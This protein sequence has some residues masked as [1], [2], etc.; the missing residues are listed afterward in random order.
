ME[1]ILSKIFNNDVSNENSNELTVKE[2]QSISLQVADE[3][4][5]KKRISN[6]DEVTYTYSAK[7]A[8][9]EANRCLQCKNPACIK[10]CPVSVKIPEFLKNVAKGDFK[11]AYE[12]LKKDTLLPSICGRVCPQEKQCQQEC[13]LGKSLKDVNKAVSIG[14]IE[15]FVADYA[16][17]HNFDD[18]FEEIKSNGK[19]VAVVGS[20]PCGLA[21]SADLRR[22]GYEVTVFE[23]FHKLGGVLIYGIPEFRLPNI[24]VEKEIEK[25]KKMGVNFIT[26]FVIGRTAT[27][28]QLKE[29]YGFQAIFISTGAGL[30]LF[31]GIEGE[32]LVGV[33]SANEFLT[34]VNLMS[35]YKEEADTPLYSAKKNSRSRGRKC[36]YGRSESSKKIRLRG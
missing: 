1:E 26:N 36:C 28:K 15:R 25:L 10:G 17:E 23:A 6:M 8:Q 27:L 30:P 9:V 7:K 21:A 18:N 24:I 16:R 11:E 4:D 20:G 34:R 35:G 5:P 31:M 3:Q 2:R 32:N 33:F 14:R 12:V 29:E 13:V 19:K 22:L